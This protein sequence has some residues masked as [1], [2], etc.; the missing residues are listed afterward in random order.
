MKFEEVLEKAKNEG[1][2]REE[3]LFLFKEAGRYNKLLELFKVA[4]KVREEEVGTV[5]KLDGCL[6]PIVPCTLNPP[7]RYCFILASKS[8]WDAESVLTLEEISTG[9]K[10]IEETGTSRIHL[11]GGSRLDATGEDVIEV[12]KVVK[13]ATNLDI[14][15]SVGPGLSEDT[16]KELKKL[17]VNEVASP[18]ETMDERLFKEVKPGDSLEIRKKLAI[19]INDVGLGLNDALMVGVHGLANNVKMDDPYEDYVNHMFYAKQFENLR[20]FGV[21]GFIPIP[22]T[23]LGDRLPPSTLEI[24]KAAAIA[25]LIFRDVDIDMCGGDILLR[26]LSGTNRSFLDGASVYKRGATGGMPMIGVR[27]EQINNIELVDSLPVTTKFIRDA[28]MDVEHGIA[29]KY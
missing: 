27:R 10:K 9:A 24:A 11:G 8:A 17:G 2:T 13:E 14:R 4:C 23:P 20:W 15:V 3:A 12:V 1:I 21:Y 28:G 16:L 5:Y 19:A 18:L 6:A 25:R 7:C 29:K 22:G 26:I